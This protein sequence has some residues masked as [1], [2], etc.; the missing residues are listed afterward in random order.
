MT[1]PGILVTGA[2][3]QLG[4]SLAKIAP[5]HELDFVFV[6]RRDLDIADANQIREYFANTQFDFCINT[7]AY[8]KVDLAEQE[9]DQAYVINADA[10]GYLSVECSRQNCVLIHISSDYV[11]DNGLH[12]PLREDDPV[13]PASVYAR[14]KLEGEVRALRENTHTVIIRTSWLFSE[15]GHNFVKTMARLM[16]EGRSLQIV[17]DQ[18]GCPTYAGD[19]ASA[20]VGIIQTMNSAPGRND[21]YGVFNYCNTGSTTWY[22][23]AIEIASVL[24]V[25]PNI[26][27]VSSA[28]YST[29]AK[30]PHYSVLNTEKIRGVFDIEIPHWKKGLQHVLRGG[31]HI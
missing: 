12:R 23:F 15:Y 21:T 24:G 7:A 22:D 29:A 17:N 3:G 20:I 2:E 8:T 27:A 13:A 10:P 31:S 28:E 18:A 11:Y 14:T 30:R 16:E 25:I 26:R 5:L 6:S 1:K 9:K 4:R 19:L